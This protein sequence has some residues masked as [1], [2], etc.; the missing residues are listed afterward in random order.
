VPARVLAAA[1]VPVA[2]GAAAPVRALAPGRALAPAR[3]PGR[4]AG[5]AGGGCACPAASAAGRLGWPALVKVAGMAAPVAPVAR[6]A[7]RVAPLVVAVVVVLVVVAV[8]VVAWAWR[9]APVMGPAVV[10]RSR[11]PQASTTHADLVRTRM[12]LSLS[13]RVMSGAPARRWARAAG[14]EGKAS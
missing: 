8:R 10:S 11:M 6:A 2:D 5:R 1:R 12:V 4:A 7:S 3:A 14:G 9:W 13:F